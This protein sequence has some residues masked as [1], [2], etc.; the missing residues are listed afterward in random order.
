[1][2]HAWKR[3]GSPKLSRFSLTDF[4]ARFLMLI[5]DVSL[6]AMQEFSCIFEII[7]RGIWNQRKGVV[8]KK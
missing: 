8:W 1:M 5:G 6:A 3:L 4:G 7:K 2:K